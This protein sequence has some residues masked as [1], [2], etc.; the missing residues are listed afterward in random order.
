[1]EFVWLHFAADLICSVFVLLKVGRASTRLFFED[2]VANNGAGAS[3]V[4]AVSGLQRLRHSDQVYGDLGDL[5][6]RE[7]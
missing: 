2:F 7:G 6:C 3:P 5:I 4:S 1:M